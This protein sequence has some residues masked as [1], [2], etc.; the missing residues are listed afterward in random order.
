MQTITSF[1]YLVATSGIIKQ[2]LNVPGTLTVDR[3]I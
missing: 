2:D 1:E 3:G